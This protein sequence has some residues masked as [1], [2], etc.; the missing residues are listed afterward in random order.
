MMDFFKTTIGCL[1]LHNAACAETVLDDFNGL[2]FNIVPVSPSQSASFSKAISTPFGAATFTASVDYGCGMSAAAGVLTIAPVPS[3]YGIATIRYDF[4]TPVNLMAFDFLLFDTTHDRNVYPLSGI[5]LT[6][7]NGQSMGFRNTSD[8]PVAAHQKKFPYY[9]FKPVSSSWIYY[10]EEV[11]AISY[12][13][14]FLGGNNLVIDKVALDQVAARKSLAATI[15]MGG[16]YGLIVEGNR[17]MNS[18]EL[19][20]LESSNDL[21]H[22]AAW[23]SFTTGT[24]KVPKFDISFSTPSFDRISWFNQVPQE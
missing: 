10:P 21:V 20:R 19:C 22:W 14:E 23:S 8:S 9:G 16:P 24:G 13:L 7:K 12:K 1:L 3:S 6:M 17:I 11:V 5:Y 15:R 18:D 2:D 4:A